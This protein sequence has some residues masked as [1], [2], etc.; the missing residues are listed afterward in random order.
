M[1]YQNDSMVKCFPNN[2]RRH[3]SKNRNEINRLFPN[4]LYLQDQGI[5]TTSAPL[6]CEA[7][8]AAAM[9]LLPTNK[10]NGGDKEETKK[11]PEDVQNIAQKLDLY[12]HPKPSPRAPG[13]AT[14][15]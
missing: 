15:R 6:V 8:K 10:E 7:I 3:H 14:A 2:F 9:G 12:N 13:N 11:I 5:D 1:D 4:H